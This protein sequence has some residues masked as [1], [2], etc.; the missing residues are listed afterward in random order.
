MAI[1]LK[2]MTDE[3]L[4]EFI[5]ISEHNEEYDDEEETNYDNEVI[6]IYWDCEKCDAEKEKEHRYQV[7]IS[8]EPGNLPFMKNS[9]S[10]SVLAIEVR[11]GDFAKYLSRPGTS[12]YPYEYAECL[13]VWCDPDYGRISIKWRKTNT[14]ENSFYAVYDST[15][16][17]SI[18]RAL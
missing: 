10:K 11:T 13:E 4:E 17:V 6:H 15:D 9:I 1:D 12:S 2:E 3:Q 16:N 7:Q 18:I 5:N 8:K 14:T